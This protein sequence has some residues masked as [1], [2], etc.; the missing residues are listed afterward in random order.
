M[1]CLI[2]CLCGRKW[3]WSVHFFCG[4]CVVSP[5]RM[6]VS[7]HA[8]GLR[9]CSFY[10]AQFFRTCTP[11]HALA[12]E[13]LKCAISPLRDAW[14]RL[15][16][17]CLKALAN[18]ATVTIA[19]RVRQSLLLSD[20]P[21]EAVAASHTTRRLMSVIKRSQVSQENS[22]TIKI[23]TPQSARKQWTQPPQPAHFG[24]PTSGPNIRHTWKKKIVPLLGLI[25]WLDWPTTSRHQHI[26]TTSDD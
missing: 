7:R 6:S 15:L 18:A 13:W 9:I 3:Q 23:Q 11:S 25:D 8:Y 22:E 5:C 19:K 12:G 2:T 17:L 4:V 24:R 1:T 21:T 16:S 10:V 20:P 14:R 26:S